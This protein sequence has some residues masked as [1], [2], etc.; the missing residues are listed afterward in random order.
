MPEEQLPAII[1]DKAI[2]RKVTKGGWGKICHPGVDKVWN[3]SREKKKQILAMKE[4][5]GSRTKQR[6]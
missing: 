5:R 3:A 4:F 2:W 6:I 1:V